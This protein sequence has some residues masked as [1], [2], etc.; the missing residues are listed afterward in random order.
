MTWGRIDLTLSKILIHRLVTS[1]TDSLISNAHGFDSYLHFLPTKYFFRAPQKHIAHRAPA[2]SPP[3]R[4]KK[5]KKMASAAGCGSQTPPPHPSSLET[6]LH[7]RS[8][9]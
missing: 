1:T 2:Y 5:K 3:S 8:K 9:N 6:A 4:S 7:F